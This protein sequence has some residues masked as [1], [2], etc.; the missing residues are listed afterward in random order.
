MA[1]LAVD[2][3]NTVN[4]STAGSQEGTLVGRNATTPVGFFGATPVVRPV[5]TSAATTVQIVA[6]LTA[7][8]LV[9]PT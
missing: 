1:I 2:T 9:S 8:G 4:A 7:L 6:A 3:Q 5:V